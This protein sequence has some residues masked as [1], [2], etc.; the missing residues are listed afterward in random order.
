MRSMHPMGVMQGVVGSHTVRVGKHF[1]LGVA[2]PR[3]T[4][5]IDLYTYNGKNVTIFPVYGG[6][7]KSKKT[8]VAL[9]AWPVS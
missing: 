4:S 2:P 3:N 8:S 9:N 5:N 7:W 6:K 1:L